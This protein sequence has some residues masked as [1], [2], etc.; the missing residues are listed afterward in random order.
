MPG[1]REYS[2]FMQATID[3]NVLDR[4]LDPVARCL[5]PDGARRLVALRIDPATQRYLDDLAAKANEGELSPEERAEY[6]AFVEAIDF[7]AILQE[8]AR[9]LLEEAG[10][11]R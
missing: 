8:K 10:A 11:E 2:G 5:A 1:A 9:T 3:K 7:I 4:L 6:A